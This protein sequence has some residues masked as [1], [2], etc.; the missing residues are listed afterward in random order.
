MKT[1]TA[2]HAPAQW[3]EILSWVS[4]GEEVQL[5]DKGRIIATVA[6]AQPVKSP[7]FLARAKAIWGD[8]PSGIDLSALVSEGRGLSR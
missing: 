5:T 3:T 8:N 1:V 6:P 2:E 4:A 7:D